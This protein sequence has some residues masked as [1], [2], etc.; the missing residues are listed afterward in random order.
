MAHDGIIVEIL[1]KINTIEN[2]SQS[3]YQH[4]FYFGISPASTTTFN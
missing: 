1:N 3:L 4:F 2:I